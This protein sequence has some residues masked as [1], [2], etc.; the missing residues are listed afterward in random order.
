MISVIIPMYNREKSIKRSVDSVLNQTYKNIEVFVIDDGSTDNGKNIINSYSDERLHLISYEKNRGANYARNLGI[1][2]AK[3]DYIAFHDSDDEWVSNKLEVQLEYMLSRELKASFS[4][5]II[6]SSEKIVPSDYQ[7]YCEDYQ[8]VKSELRRHNIIGTPTLIVSQE[9]IRTI[10]MFDEQ[11]TRLQDYEYVIRVVQKFEI[12]CCPEILV[13]VDCDGERISNSSIKFEESLQLL[14]EKHSDFLDLDHFY[15][16]KNMFTEEDHP[17]SRET[18]NNIINAVS[19]KVGFM[20]IGLNYLKDYAE[21][22]NKKNRLLKQIHLKNLKTKE[23]AIYGAGEKG[24]EFYQELKKAGL[25][26]KYFI[27]TQKDDM[28]SD[29][30]GISI[31][32]LSDIK[33]KNIVII[34]A[35]SIANQCDILELLYENSFYNVFTI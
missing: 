21:L 33:D 6:A 4:P 32:S 23:F 11:M 24:K 17:F 25:I 26:P 18:V 34:V 31:K 9:V 28:V 5:Y 10:G 7:K 2:N 8:F 29:I 13:F 16:I 27:V 12:G 30:G 35:V 20:Q 19:N 22:N 14:I 3:G 15:G 1:K